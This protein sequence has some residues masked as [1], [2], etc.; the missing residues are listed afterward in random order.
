MA[1]MSKPVI[2]RQRYSYGKSLLE[3]VMADDNERMIKVQC[4]GCETQ[5]EVYVAV[6]QGNLV[7]L[8]GNNCPTGEVYALSQAKRQ[9]ENRR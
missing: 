9:G 1:K 3:C 8:G 7:C 4:Q 6:R 5:C 2:L